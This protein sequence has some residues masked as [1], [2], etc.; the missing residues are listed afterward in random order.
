MSSRIISSDHL[1]PAMFPG[2]ASVENEHITSTQ[3]SVASLRS[4]FDPSLSKDHATLLAAAEKAKSHFQSLPATENRSS[5]VTEK[6]IQKERTVAQSAATSASEA[7]TQAIPVINAL[8]YNCSDK[9]LLSTVAKLESRLQHASEQATQNASHATSATQK[10]TVQVDAKSAV[11][12]AADA[13]LTL[14]QLHQLEPHRSE[15]SSKKD[16]ANLKKAETDYQNASHELTSLLKTTSPL[17]EVVH[18]DKINDLA[19]NEEVETTDVEVSS[20][21]D[22]V[23]RD[24]ISIDDNSSVIEDDEQ[25]DFGNGT[26]KE[27]D[28][29]EAMRRAKVDSMNREDRRI[30]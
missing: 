13:R 30:K 8:R 24:S 2:S 16:E 18:H 6:I 10:Q 1:P 20:N 5:I 3:K 11:L 21:N 14:A 4:F 19:S 7:Q 17:F 23:Q 26:W 25:P 22:S 28:D 29:D 9:E 27:V 15:K 12:H